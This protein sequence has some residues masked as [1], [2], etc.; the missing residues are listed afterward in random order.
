MAAGTRAA[1][2]IDAYIAKKKG[3]VPISRPNPL[4]GDPPPPFP[5]GYGGPTW[6]L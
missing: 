2:A 1:V 6:H 3:R 5:P 4:G